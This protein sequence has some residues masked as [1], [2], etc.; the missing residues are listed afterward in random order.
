MLRNVSLSLANVGHSEPVA[1]CFAHF[2]IVLCSNVFQLLLQRVNLINDLDEM[3][4][5]E[6]NGNE[7][8]GK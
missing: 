4:L 3:N 6:W 7:W 1:K 8:N 5:N 2:A